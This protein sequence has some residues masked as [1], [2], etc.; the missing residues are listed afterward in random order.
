MDN[1]FTE[2]FTEKHIVIALDIFVR[3]AGFFSEADLKAPTFQAFVRE[4]GRNL[5]TFQ[6]ERSYVKTARF[7]DIFCVDDKY[8]WVNLEMFLMKKEKMFSPKSVVEIMSHFSS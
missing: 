6:D 5:V 4:L 3:D 7:L 2:G 8:L 1:M